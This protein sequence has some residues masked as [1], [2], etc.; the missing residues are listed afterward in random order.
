MAEGHGDGGD[1]EREHGEEAGVEGGEGEQEEAGEAAEAE[2]VEVMRKHRVLA[3]KLEA[4][5]SGGGSVGRGA[6]TA[7]SLGTT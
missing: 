2:W 3:G 1:G 7:S 5:A 4:L 6:A